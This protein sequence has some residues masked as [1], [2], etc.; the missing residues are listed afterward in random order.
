MDADAEPARHLPERDS[1]VTILLVNR[2]A[3]QLQSV[4]E[5]QPGSHPGELA[6]Q[7]HS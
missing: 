5:S 7:Q 3:G 2:R 6:W 4:T 1:S